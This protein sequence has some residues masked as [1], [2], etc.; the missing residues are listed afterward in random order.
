LKT[1]AKFLIAIALITAC[2]LWAGSLDRNNFLGLGLFIVM[3]SS[4]ASIASASSGALKAWR[5]AKIEYQAPTTEAGESKMFKF[6][7]GVMGV[8]QRDN[9]VTMQQQIQEL[10]NVAV[11]DEKTW[12]SLIAMTNYRVD[13]CLARL[14]YHEEVTLPKLLGESAGTVIVSATMAFVGSAYLA[15]PAEFYDLFRQIYEYFS[16]LAADLMTASQ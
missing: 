3:A 4:F 10:R 14:E 16:G 12:R 2:S 15:Y 9:L 6:V 5:A 7:A 13:I 1:T 8:S 11:Q